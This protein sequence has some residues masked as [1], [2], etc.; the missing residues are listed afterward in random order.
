VADH[1]LHTYAELESARRYIK[2]IHRPGEDTGM[3]SSDVDL[4]TIS[5]V[6]HELPQGATKYVLYTVYQI[7][8][9]ASTTIHHHHHY[10]YNYVARDILLEAYRILPLG[11]AI[12]IM[13]MN[14][15]STAFRRVSS[16]P[17]AFAA[18][19]STE[20][21]IQEYVSMDLYDMLR[22]CGFRD[23]DMMENS[24]RHRTVVAYK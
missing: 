18:F 4:V 21:W 24:P 19:K 22:V 9:K 13:D 10:Y 1:Q 2:Y 6:S 12:A 3:G 11:G 15:D 5:L 16:N 23:V 8:S 17:F 7:T 14:P 20:P